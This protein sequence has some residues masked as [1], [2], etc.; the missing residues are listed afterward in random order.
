ME[1]EPRRATNDPDEVTRRGAAGRR[2]VALVAGV[3][4]VVVLVVWLIL[5]L[6][7]RETSDESSG[8]GPAPALSAVQ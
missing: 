5:Y 7:A 4:L 8:P 2:L 6:T 1:E 3:V